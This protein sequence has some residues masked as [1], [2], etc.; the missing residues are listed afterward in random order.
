MN[1]NPRKY[2]T[3]FAIVG[4]VPWLYGGC[5]GSEVPLGSSRDA[6]LD[7]RL[8]GRWICPSPGG[9]E[10]GAL[11]FFAFDENQYYVEMG[12]PRKITERF[13]AYSTEVK[14]ITFLNAQDLH[15]H[16]PPE[17]RGYYFARYSI[18]K[19]DLLTVRI[20]RESRLKGSEKTTAAIKAALEQQI[21]DRELYDDSLKC[22]KST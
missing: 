9:E 8:V 19:N 17:K 21:D 5:H 1:A 16:G 3:I 6:K 12:A 10:V 20:V 15:K 22:T 13:R 2:L 18:E 4:C 7:T 11:G 14:G